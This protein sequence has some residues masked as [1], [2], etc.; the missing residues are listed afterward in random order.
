MCCV[1]DDV[2][3]FVKFYE[4]KIAEGE[5]KHFTKM[6]NKTKAKIQLLAD[7]SKE[8]KT[9]KAKLKQKLEKP[10]GSM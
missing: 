3:R 6:F 9:E 1:N 7:E 8:A 4:E 10:Q 2:P 5:I